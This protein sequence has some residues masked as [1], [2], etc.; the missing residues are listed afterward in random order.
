MCRGYLQ[1]PAAVLPLRSDGKLDVGH[2]VGEGIL[3]V[4]KDI[5]AGEPFSGKVE[6]RS[7]EIAEDVAAY[8]T[9]SEQIPSACALDVLVD[10]SQSVCAAGG[11]MLQLLPGAP[12]GLADLLEYR[13]QDVGSVTAAMERGLTPEALLEELLYGMDFSVLEKHPVSYRCRCSQERVERALISMGKEEL[14][15]LI[16]AE[17]ETSVT[18]QFCDAVYRFDKAQL[19]AL[20]TRAGKRH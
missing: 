10:T 16:A 11:Y 1:N 18:C 2:G 12:A 17:E 3:T 20:I 15:K 13:V 9:L 5:G 4:L 19:K 8:Y 6:L 14:E 7:G